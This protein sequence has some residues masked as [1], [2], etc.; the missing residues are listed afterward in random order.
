[1]DMKRGTNND[2]SRHGPSEATTT[3]HLK[4]SATL[5]DLLDAMIAQKSRERS[6]TRML[7]RTSELISAC[8]GKPTSAIQVSQLIMAGQALKTFLAGKGYNPI[9]VQIYLNYLQV[10]VESAE[11]LGWMGRFADLQRSWREVLKSRPKRVGGV[12]VINWAIGQ[13]IDPDHFG[14][15]ELELCASEAIQ[16]GHAY[17]S[18]C[19]VK[20]HL[21]RLMVE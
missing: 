11:E 3:G 12:W 17:G 13:G 7:R 20:R 15:A 6:M 16:H 14:T 2:K 9:T 21:R 1:M 4:E 5:K 19:E 10:F 18:V 8:L